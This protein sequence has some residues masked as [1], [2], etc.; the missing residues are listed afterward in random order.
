MA[1]Y[2]RLAVKLPSGLS[3]EGQRAEELL[4]YPKIRVFFRIALV[5]LRTSART[6]KTAIFLLYEVVSRSQSVVL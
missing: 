5:H 3:F 2:M 4:Q 1:E 6:I